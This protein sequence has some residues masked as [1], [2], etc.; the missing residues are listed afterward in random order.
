ML[1]SILLSNLTVQLLF[2]FVL[3]YF[4]NET[5]YNVLKI[6]SNINIFIIN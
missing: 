6:V 1:H 2:F 5:L 4:T 3:M